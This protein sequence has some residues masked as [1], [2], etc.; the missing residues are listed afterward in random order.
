[1]REIP[2]PVSNKDTYT[3]DIAFGFELEMEK[4][5]GWKGAK[6]IVSGLDL[7]GSSFSLVDVGNQLTV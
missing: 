2:R 1:L 7:N 4:L 3:D 6:S 5:V